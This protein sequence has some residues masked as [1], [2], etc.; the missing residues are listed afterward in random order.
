MDR[1]IW[2]RIGALALVIS[3]L[4]I[5]LRARRD[6]RNAA[7]I[8]VSPRVAACLRHQSRRKSP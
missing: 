5:Q 3:L 1:V 4:G 8:S 6:L 7:R 2:K